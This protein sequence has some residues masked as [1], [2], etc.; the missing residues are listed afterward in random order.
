MFQFNASLFFAFCLLTFWLFDLYFKIAFHHSHSTIS[1]CRI[2]NSSGM[3]SNRSVVDLFASLSIQIYAFFFL[4][5]WIHLENLFNLFERIAFFT[6]HFIL[7]ALEI[8]AP[9][10]STR[11]SFSSVFVGLCLFFLEARRGLTRCKYKRT[12]SHMVCS[13]MRRSNHFESYK[14]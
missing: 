12:L 5:F 10:I 6:K 11:V 4:F 14:N 8:S 1:I 3:F 9:F 7:C 2:N 13:K